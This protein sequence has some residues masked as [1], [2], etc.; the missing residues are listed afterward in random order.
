[1]DWT[2]VRSGLS[3]SF[4]DL[5]VVAIDELERLVIAMRFSAWVKVEIDDGLQPN[6]LDE[7]PEWLFVYVPTT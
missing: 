1:M 6:G 3:D 7:S 4:H 2:K 5:K